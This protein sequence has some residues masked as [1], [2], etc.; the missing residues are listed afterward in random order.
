MEH[1][2]VALSE[3]LRKFG[4][5]IGWIAKTLLEKSFIVNNEDNPQFSMA[6]NRHAVLVALIITVCSPCT[7]ST[8]ERLSTPVN[9]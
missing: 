6:I 8:L 7:S 1:G 5:A 9:Q 3:I 2:L 4:E